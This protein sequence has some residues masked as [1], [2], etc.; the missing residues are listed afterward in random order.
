MRNTAMMIK[1]GSVYVFASAGF[2][3]IHRIGI[4]MHWRTMM[5]MTPGLYWL[6]ERG[7]WLMCI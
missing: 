4:G 7:K 3:Y 2:V 6:D 5:M 1:A